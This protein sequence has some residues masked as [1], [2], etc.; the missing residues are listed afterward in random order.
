MLPPRIVGAVA[1]QAMAKWSYRDDALD[2]LGD[3]LDAA[4]AVERV[5]AADV[6]REH[7]QL[8][9]IAPGSQASYTGADCMPWAGGGSGAAATGRG[10][11]RGTA[12]CDW[13]GGP[14]GTFRWGLAVGTSGGD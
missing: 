9:V 11:V 7:R 1:T 8:G 13:P 10:G 4:A 14:A 3:G 12:V 2:L 5:T 6:D